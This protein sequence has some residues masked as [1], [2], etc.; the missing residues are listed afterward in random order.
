MLALLDPRID[1]NSLEAPSTR[2]FET[3]QLIP[4][5]ESINRLLVD[6][7]VRRNVPHGH[8]R[9]GIHARLP[10]LRNLGSIVQGLNLA[11]TR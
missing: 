10:L 2:D 6:I 5:S 11:T 7:E 4:L 8:G 3:R 9:Q 1:I